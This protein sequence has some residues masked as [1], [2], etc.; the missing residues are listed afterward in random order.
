MTEIELAVMALLAFFWL[1]YFPH[2]F[3]L[4]SLRVKKLES[5]CINPRDASF[6]G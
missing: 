4:A 1:G 2:T 3:A 6:I 5:P